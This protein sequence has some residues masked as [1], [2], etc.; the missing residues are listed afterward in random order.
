[1][2]WP[3]PINVAHTCGAFYNAQCGSDI[4]SVW[5]RFAGMHGN[6]NNIGTMASTNGGIRPLFYRI[7]IETERKIEYVMFYN[8]VDSNFHRIDL[9]TIRVGNDITSTQNTICATLNATLIQNRSCGVSGR[10]ISIVHPP[11]ANVEINFLE[12][13]VYTTR[14]EQCPAGKYKDITGPD[15]CTD[16]PPNMFSLPGSI[17]PAACTGCM[18]GFFES[19]T[20]GCTACPAGTYKGDAGVSACIS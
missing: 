11:N 14:C 9:S 5:T 10:Y 4:T 13:E 19:N 7:N 20:G 1:M 12:L 15:T 17:S 3:F 16:C 2:G 8:R 6:D 18:P